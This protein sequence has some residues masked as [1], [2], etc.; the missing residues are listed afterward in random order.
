MQLKQSLRIAEVEQGIE[1][2]EIYYTGN[3][4]KLRY[5]IDYLSSETGYD[6]MPLEF[7]I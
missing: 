5:L 1:F 6:L 2:N 3:G 7:N 4:A